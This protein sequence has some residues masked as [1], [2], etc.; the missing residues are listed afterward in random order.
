[1]TLSCACDFWMPHGPADGL[2]LLIGGCGLF[3]LI[4]ACLVYLER[5]A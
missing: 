2:G 3:L 4:V 5:R 1:M